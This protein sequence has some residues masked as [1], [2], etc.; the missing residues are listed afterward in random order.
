M[1]HTN[2]I[3]R[4]L[5]TLFTMIVMVS[6][7]V[8]GVRNRGNFL[9]TADQRGQRLLDRGE[10]DEAAEAFQD[11][12]RRAVALSRAGDFK[13]AASLFST[14]PG[15]D[16]AFNQANMLVMLGEYEPATKRYDQTIKL[17]PTWEAASKNRAIAAGRAAR[18]QKDGGEMTGGKLGADEIVFDQSN[19]P[20]G[21][22]EDEDE[23]IQGDTLSDSELQAMWLR[24]VKTT[25][26]DFLRSKFAFQ[27]AMREQAPSDARAE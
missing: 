5:A 10:Y 25:P 12:F 4:R 17:R 8:I 16:A 11:P 21:T 9:L 18:L 3:P 14:I 15:P 27:Q 13:R 20:G 23:T 7:V 1:N 6:G 22:S 26:R 24:Q 2:R 19:S